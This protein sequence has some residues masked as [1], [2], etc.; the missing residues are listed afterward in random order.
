MTEPE[1]SL[2]GDGVNRRTVLKSAAVGLSGSAF[3]GA[4]SAEGWNSLEFCAADDEG[5]FQ[6]EVHVSEAIE[7]DGSTDSGDEVFADGTAVR[8]A[9]GE[10]RCDG[11]RFRGEITDLE[12]DGRGTVSVNGSVIR[13][14]TGDDAAGG[15]GGGEEKEL[16]F[17]SV[18]DRL[19]SYR[20]SVSGSIRRAPNRD[21]GDTRIDD[22]T[23]E[24]RARGGNHDDWFFTGEVTELRLDGPG[25]VLVDGEVVADT[26]TGGTRTVVVSSPD[27]EAFLD[28]SFV[29]DGDVH[30]LEPDEDAGDAVDEI[31]PLDDGRT[32]VEGSV[33]TG[34]DRFEITG[35][36]VGWRLPEGVVLEVR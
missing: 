6:Y 21:G 17:Q 8:G 32:R 3:A 14:T 29:V 19:F 9:A 12:L 10:G 7:S 15:G 36:I 31:V 2:S 23:A 5:Y 33:S 4:A 25:R 1:R 24:G 20:V 26:T 30:K 34:D 22:R 11:W 27:T 13:D 35:P 16:R 28:Y 18:D